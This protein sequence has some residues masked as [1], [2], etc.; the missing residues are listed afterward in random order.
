MIC[1]CQKMSRVETTIPRIAA[2]NWMIA[3]LADAKSRYHY[4]WSMRVGRKSENCC[5][6]CGN[7]APSILEVFRNLLLSKD[8]DLFQNGPRLANRMLPAQVRLYWCPET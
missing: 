4:L 1:S 3:S 2:R 6:Y 8:L 5:S 7:P